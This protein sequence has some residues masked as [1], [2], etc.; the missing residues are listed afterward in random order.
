MNKDRSTG[1]DAYSERD[2]KPIFEEMIGDSTA[3]QEGWE[4][5]GFVP[6][7][8]EQRE[9]FA[10]IHAEQ[11]KQWEAAVIVGRVAMV[12]I[13]RGDG[14]MILG[15]PDIQ[16]RRHNLRQM[17]GTGVEVWEFVV[18]QSTRVISPDKTRGDIYANIAIV[19]F[20]K[21]EHGTKIPEA[22][23]SPEQVA[24]VGRHVAQL[25]ALRANPMGLPNLSWSLTS[26][27]DPTARLYDA[28]SRG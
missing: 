12:L 23:F 28:G 3:G 25:D 6:S 8:A 2:Y 17:N 19:P 20:A 26:V 1:S 9:R 27:A 18:D 21:I 15:S 16:L 11:R 5:H 10:E 7:P 22:G 24:L 14:D 4:M 13:D